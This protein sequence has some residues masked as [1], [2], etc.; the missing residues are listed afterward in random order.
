M[1]ER[2]ARILIVEDETH[3]A[4]GLKLNLQFEGF[5]VDVASTARE[6]AQLLL[7]PEAY[8]LLVLDVML[9]DLDGFALCRQLRDAGNFTPL[10]MLT[11]RSS[12]ED[13]V[14]GLEAGADDYIVKPFELAE[15]LARIRS[16]LRRSSW[17]QKTQE[18]SD[19][20]LQFGQVILNLETR[21]VTQHGELIELTRLEFDLLRYFIENPNRVIN[22]GELL[23]KVWHLK[24]Y[25]NARTVDNFL[26]RLRK[27]FEADPQ[28]PVHFL[29]VRGTGYRFIPSLPK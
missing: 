3:L 4:I 29:S 23:E 26:A 8:Q 24:N 1:N 9:P 13:R 22:R 6:A 20:I 7:H 12:A 28:N 27:Y 2:K 5:L 11:A 17:N 16:A 10:F 15:L 18:P 21:Q 19:P 14:T 25:P